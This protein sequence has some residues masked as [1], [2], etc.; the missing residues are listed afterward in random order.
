M[1]LTKNERAALTLFKRWL[2]RKFGKR[3]QELALFGSRARGE[4]HEHSDLDVLVVV[5]GLRTSEGRE[6]AK[7]RGDYLTK[8]CVWISPFAVSDTHMNRLRQ[9]QRLIAYEI[10]RDALSL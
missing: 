3:L 6:I 5:R 4:G 9:R 8:F 7:K 10:Q 1:H 2:M